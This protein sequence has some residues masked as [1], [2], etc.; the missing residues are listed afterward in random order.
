MLGKLIKHDFISTWKTIVLFNVFMVAFTLLGVLMFFMRIWESE[1]IWVTFLGMISFLFYYLS[2]FGIFI[3]LSVFIALHFYK[4]LFSDEGYLIHTLPVT[5]RQILLSKYIVS[6]IYTAGTCLIIL[7]S[8]WGLFTSFILSTGISMSEISSTLTLEI[9]PAT[10]L[11]KTALNFSFLEGILFII[12]TIWGTLF[13]GP[14][15]IFSSI[16]L[17][18]LFTKHKVAGSLL[19]YFGSYMV[20]QIAVIF[21]CLPLFR[22]MFYADSSSIDMLSSVKLWLWI[23]VLFQAVYVAFCF[24]LSEYLMKKKLN[25]S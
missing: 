6:G 23:T 5:P 2:I 17:G 16:S 1:A 3:A 12:V 14:A 13:A 25:L 10:Q 11:A 15:M 19:S 18:Q 20:I 4:S 7:I 24:F 22:P 8:V 9:W 21:T